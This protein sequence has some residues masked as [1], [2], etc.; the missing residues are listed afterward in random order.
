MIF[1]T[2]Y[3]GESDKAMGFAA[4]ADDYLTNHFPMQSF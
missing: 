2:A 1:L 4:G 3:A